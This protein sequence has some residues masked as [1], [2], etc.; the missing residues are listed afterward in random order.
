[1]LSKWIII[2]IMFQR[3]K[4][5]HLTSKLSPRESN[6][7]STRSR[8]WTS[9]SHLMTDRMESK[10]SSISIKRKSTNPRRSLLPPESSIDT[11]TWLELKTSQSLKWYPSLPFVSLCQPNLSNPSH[12]ASQEWSTS[13]PTRKKNTSVNNH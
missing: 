2:S 12:Q 11:F 5:A 7:H 13:L 8:T 9:K 3:L 6:Q 4:Q 10:R 1:M